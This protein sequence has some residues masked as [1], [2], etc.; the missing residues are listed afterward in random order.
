MTVKGRNDLT[1]FPETYV[2]SLNGELTSEFVI[3][4]K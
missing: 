1:H 2:I 3:L 4:Y